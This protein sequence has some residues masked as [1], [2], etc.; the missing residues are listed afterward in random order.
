MCPPYILMW[1]SVM[2]QLNDLPAIA[3]ANRNLAN[4]LGL[5]ATKP[6]SLYQ[7]ETFDH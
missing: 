4:P 1:R 2:R 3:P 5:P 6:D 7:A